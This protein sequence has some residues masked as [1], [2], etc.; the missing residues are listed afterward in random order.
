M[1]GGIM[2]IHKQTVG[3]NS[4][5]HS[6]NDTTEMMIS[7]I[8]FVPLPHASSDQKRTAKRTFMTSFVFQKSA[9][10]KNQ[11]PWRYKEQKCPCIQ[12]FER[13][14]VQLN[15]QRQRNFSP[16]A[17]LLMQ[18]WKQW[19]K[20]QRAMKKFH[21]SLR[22]NNSSLK[23][24]QNQIRMKNRGPSGPIGKIVIIPMNPEVTAEAE[25]FFEVHHV[26]KIRIE[27]NNKD[28]GEEASVVETIENHKAHRPKSE[29]MKIIVDPGTMEEDEINK[30]VGR[31]QEVTIREVKLIP[32]GTLE[33]QVTEEEVEMKTLPLN[34]TKIPPH[35]SVVTNGKQLNP[36]PGT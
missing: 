18:I 8:A 23:E 1:P 26:M 7:S 30:F 13:N 22:Q 20:Q 5:M 12:E 4:K 35:T 2:F 33:I 9:F 11:W 15:M 19:T 3:M 17:K 31:G 16:L 24:N 21:R 29:A 28:N 10:R 32:K 14:W 34:R 6:Q 36:I 25:E 27:A